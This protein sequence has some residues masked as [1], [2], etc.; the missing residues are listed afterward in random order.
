M[1]IRPLQELEHGTPGKRFQSIYR[2]RQRSAHAAWKNGGFI[3]GGL[4]VIAAGV[5]T[6]PVPVIP[7]EIVI[8]A[9]LALLAQGSS[10]GAKLFD[11]AEVRLRRWLAPVLPLWR[12]LP[13]WAQVV[14]GLVWSFLVA[15]LVYWAMHAL[16][17]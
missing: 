15:G 11:A 2:R 8:V 16:R 5:A 10:H 4:L 7:S 1:T 3:V 13:K 12:R 6:Y 9:G 14:L 17:D